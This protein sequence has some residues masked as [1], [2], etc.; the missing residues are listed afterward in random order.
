MFVTGIP[1]SKIPETWA[2]N[3]PDNKGNK[4]SCLTM[5]FN[6]ELA[7]LSCSETRPYVCYRSGDLRQ[8][9]NGCGTTDPGKSYTR[10]SLQERRKGS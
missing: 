3:E 4:E 8:G 10:E 7:D 2:P 5:N 9:I 6:G 1:L